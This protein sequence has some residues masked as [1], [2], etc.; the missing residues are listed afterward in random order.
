MRL[1]IILVLFLTHLAIFSPYALDFI[2][3]VL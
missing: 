2:K 3:E 1:A